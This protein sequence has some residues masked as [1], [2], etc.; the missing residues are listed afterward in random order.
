M[1]LR[2]RP[3]GIDIFCLERKFLAFNLI[4]RNLKIKYRHSIGGMLW[5]FLIPAASALVY[6]AVFK[7]VMR[8]QHEHYLTLL[9]AGLL[10]WTFFQTSVMNGLESIVGNRPLINKVPVPPQ[11]FPLTE[12]VTGFVNFALGLPIVAILA[13]ASGLSLS[14]SLLTLIPL[15]ALLLIQAYSLSLL[16]GLAFVYLRDLKHALGIV[17][18][19]WFYAT[20]IIYTQDMM[21]EKMRAL[22]AINPVGMIFQGIQ[23][24]WGLAAPLTMENWLTAVGWTLALFGAAL[25]LLKTELLELAE[26]L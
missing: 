3:L 10:P 15:L 26:D 6:F 24:A 14:W 13:L 20:P 25:W 18:Q 17:L 22:V 4:R 16:T 5:T 1:T 12:T 19:T 11:V 23:S 7:F 8:V 21:P 9:M 2:F